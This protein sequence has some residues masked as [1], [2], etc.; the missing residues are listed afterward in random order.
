MGQASYGEQFAALFPQSKSLVALAPVRQLDGD[1][2]AELDQP[3]RWLLLAQG[4]SELFGG[5]LTDVVSALAARNGVTLTLPDPPDQTEFRVANPNGR[6]WM[7]TD[8]EHMRGRLVPAGGIRR[9]LQH[10]GVTSSSAPSGS[11]NR[12]RS[13]S[14]FHRTTSSS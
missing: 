4:G 10:L 11:P 9:H 6:L 7:I 12:R 8:G 14:S 2:G 13:T 1:L 3:A 5:S